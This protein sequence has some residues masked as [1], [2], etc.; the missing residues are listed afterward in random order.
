MHGQAQLLE[1]RSAGRVDLRVERQ[2]I[3][4]LREDGSAKCR[5]PRGSDTAILINSSGGLAGGDTQT[6]TASA[7]TGAQLALTTQAAERVYRSLGPAADVT[8]TLSA[9]KGASLQ[10]LPQETILFEGAALR[11]HISVDL[12]DGA[13]FLAVE[14]LIFGRTERGEQISHLHLSDSWDVRYSGQLIHAERLS[15]GRAL[16]R[17][18]A[19]LSGYHALATLLLV[20]PLAESLLPALR[21]LLGPA[22]GASAWKPHGRGQGTGKLVARLLARDGYDLR[23]ALIPVLS[24]CLNGRDL[25]KV[26]TL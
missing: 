10:W 13:T 18:G 8:V 3:A 7:G 11:R 25:P 24:L 20:S 21:P 19:T 15:L 9:E 14:P 12:A 22:S 26:W 16:P 6:V 4:V 1:Q 2:G 17:S 23:K 5:M